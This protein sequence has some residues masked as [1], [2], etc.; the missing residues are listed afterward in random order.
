MIHPTV[1]WLGVGERE[2][3]FPSS[4]FILTIVPPISGLRNKQGDA[5]T[6]QEVQ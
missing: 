2:P 3:A 5:I 1:L 4:S 6:R